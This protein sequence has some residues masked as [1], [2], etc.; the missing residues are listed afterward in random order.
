MST[1]ETRGTSQGASVSCPV[2][3]WKCALLFLPDIL[4]VSGQKSVHGQSGATC[5]KDEYHVG[6]YTV[7]LP[8]IG[9][10]GG[11]TGRV[12]YCACRNYDHWNAEGAPSRSCDPCH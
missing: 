9:E 11:A 8:V 2:G 5:D 3:P 4:S 7:E 1:T 10:E 6:P 12:E